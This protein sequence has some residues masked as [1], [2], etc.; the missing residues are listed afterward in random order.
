MFSMQLFETVQEW[1]YW[2]DVVQFSH[3]TLHCFK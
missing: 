3:E 1:A 2:R